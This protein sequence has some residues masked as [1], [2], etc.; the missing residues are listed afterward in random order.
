MG[1]PC[2]AWVKSNLLHFDRPRHEEVDDSISYHAVGKSFD[3]MVVAKSDMQAVTLFSAI[4][5]RYGVT[6]SCG[7]TCHL[8]DCTTNLKSVR[9]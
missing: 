4:L 2:E 7:V 3:G 1:L 5:H 9:Q 6:I 8:S